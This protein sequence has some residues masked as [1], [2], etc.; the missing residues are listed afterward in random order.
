MSNQ[1]TFVDAFCGV[2]DMGLSWAR[3]C[4]DAAKREHSDGIPND[5]VIKAKAVLVK[6]KLA[7]QG[8]SAKT[9]ANRATVARKILRN[10]TAL[11]VALPKVEGDKSWE[12]PTGRGFDPQTFEKLVTLAHKMH[13]DS[14]KVPTGTALATKFV[15]MMKAP[16]ASTTPQR[17][18]E[19]AFKAMLNSGT[20]AAKWVAVIEA[21]CKEARKQGIA[22]PE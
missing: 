21:A 6:S 2:V 15:T 5:E 9:Q 3:G 17:K 16:K 11:S 20:A 8:K 10:H 12:R 22:I 19:N 4:L 13:E 7:E 1:A 18:C 14:G